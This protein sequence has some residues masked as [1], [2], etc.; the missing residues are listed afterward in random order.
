MPPNI[1]ATPRWVDNLPCDLAQCHVFAAIACATARIIVLSALRTQRVIPRVRPE[2][3]IA[4]VQS[5]YAAEMCA[6]GDCLSF[7]RWRAMPVSADLF[8]SD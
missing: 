4:S 3:C 6:V 5:G 8:A 2:N 1:D 7:D